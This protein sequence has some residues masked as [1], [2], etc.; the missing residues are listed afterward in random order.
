[1]TKPESETDPWAKVKRRQGTVIEHGPGVLGGGAWSAKAA[2]YLAKEV[3][4]ARAAEAAQHRQEI[5]AKDATIKRIQNAAR[6]LVD[7]ADR[8][9][10]AEVKRRVA[11][12][13]PT[14][15]SEREMNAILTD[16]NDALRVRLAAVE[17]ERDKQAEQIADLTMHKASRD[18]QLGCL[19]EDIGGKKYPTMNEAR[20]QIAAWKAMTAE[21]DRLKAALQDV[22]IGMDRA[23]GD[24]DGMP[25][26]PWCQSQ[27]RP[28]DAEEG[29]AHDVDC[30]LMMARAAL[31]TQGQS[32][33]GET[34]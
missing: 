33:D 13:L 34:K 28:E 16:E 7:G 1:M 6:V 29:Y 20:D 23:G 26:C 4:A 32:T 30:S 31:T 27:G 15:D 19:L 14:L 9:G 17:A 12:G 10:E 8:R 3:D 2:V 24:R 11:A 22:T 5:A 18:S 25:E 21:R